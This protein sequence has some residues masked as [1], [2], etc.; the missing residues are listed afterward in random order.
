MPESKRLPRVSPSRPLKK[1]SWAKTLGRT[2]PFLITAAVALYL[3]GTL[4]RDTHMI[5]QLKTEI[6]DMRRQTEAETQNVAMLNSDL[7]SLLL[8]DTIERLARERIHLVKP[9]EELFRLIPEAR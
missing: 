9:N 5:W 3:L 2:S 7:Q 4:A 1:E 8:P 6:R